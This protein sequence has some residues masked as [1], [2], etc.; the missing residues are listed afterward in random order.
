[1]QPLAPQEGAQLRLDHY[2]VFLSG[3][4]VL[5][6]L[7]GHHAPCR[8]WGYRNTYPKGT[9]PAQPPRQGRLGHPHLAQGG[10]TGPARRRHLAHHLGPETVYV[11]HC[12]SLASPPAWVLKDR[13]RLQATGSPYG[14][15]RSPP[16]EPTHA[17]LSAFPGDNIADTE[18][19]PSR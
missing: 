2:A 11:L 19:D 15:L 13:G 8:V 7:H 14:S 3:R 4:P 16:G 6:S 17:Y 9:G 18:G 1:M 5:R 12:L 10:G